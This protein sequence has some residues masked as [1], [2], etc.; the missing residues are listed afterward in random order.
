[1]TEAIQET[2]T[3]RIVKYSVEVAKIAELKEHFGS[4]EITDTESYEAA[5]VGLR[6]MVHLRKV[7]ESEKKEKNA[8]A[9]AWQRSV[10]AGA[11]R[12]I[13]MIKEVEDPL[14][15]KKKI[16]DD[17]EKAEKEERARIKREDEL[18][19]VNKI[20]DT[21][22][23]IT[24]LGVAHSGMSV[25][26]MRT[27]LGYLKNT[28]I[29]EGEFQEF[30]ANADRAHNDAIVSIRGAIDAYEENQSRKAELEAQRKEQEAER[31]RLRLEREEMDRKHEVFEK[32]QKELQAKEDELRVAKEEEAAK[33]EMAAKLEADAEKA[34]ADLDEKKRMAL[35]REEERRAVIDAMRPD[36]E[37]ITAYG[38]DIYALWKDSPAV[39]HPRAVLIMDEV[40]GLMNDAAKLCREQP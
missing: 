24:S 4:L 28:Q 37:K 27:N 8:D 9:L 34:R 29:T 40:K 30:H 2:K 32:Q 38:A 23:D 7:I 6:G 33:K 11:K 39:D 20:N 19:R 35:Y 18:A 10:N 21:I 14:K 16:V 5:R 12:L 22:R 36:G 3:E 13:T 15:E 31:E 25:D 26:D 17:K 1:M